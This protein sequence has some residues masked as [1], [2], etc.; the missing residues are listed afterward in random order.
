MK[1]RVPKVFVLSL[2]FLAFC[3]PAFGQ[4]AKKHR[5]DSVRMVYMPPQQLGT[6]TVDRFY[7]VVH[8]SDPVDTAGLAAMKTNLTLTYPESGASIPPAAITKV[9]VEAASGNK[10]ININLDFSNKA[11]APGPADDAVQVQFRDL[12]F[13]VEGK[14]SVSATLTGVGKVY[15]EQTLPALVTDLQQGLKDSVANAKT[16]DEK[17]IFAGLNVTIPSGGA[18]SGKERSGEIHIN[19]TLFSPNFGGALLADSIQFGLHLNKGSADRADPRHFSFGFAYRKTFLRMNQRDVD[20][21]RS[22]LFAGPGDTATPDQAR[23]T[24]ARAVEAMA[25]LQQDFVRAFIFDNA[26]RFEGDVKG[27]A[28]G[29]VSNLL[30]ESQF[31]IATVTRALAGRNSFWN[32]RLVPAGAEVGFNLTNQENTAQEGQTLA[33]VKGGATFSLYYETDSTSQSLSKVELETKGVVRYL[34]RPESAFNALTNSAVSIDEGAKYWIEANLKFLLGPKLQNARTGLRVGF[35]QGFL[36]PV[37]AYTKTFTVSLIL[38][39]ND[40]T[41]SKEISL[42]R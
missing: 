24:E 12:A 5:I 10:I 38:E 21:I 11:A 15:N 23:K 31:Q 39:T 42:I 41:T 2:V 40:A 26:L 14:Q 1:T 35:S 9:E 19:R 20:A 7:V 6:L 8:V 33:R 34:F 16:S 13:M 36:P 27:T 25:S 22:V 4:Q 3:L 29:N 18:S 32:L 17:N 37:Y 30:Y 28:I